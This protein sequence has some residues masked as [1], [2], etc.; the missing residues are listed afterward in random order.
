MKN[1]YFGVLEE[2]EDM[3]SILTFLASEIIE[4][5]SWGKERGIFFLIFC[6]VGVGTCNLSEGWSV[7]PSASFFHALRVGKPLTP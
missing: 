2:E 5:S 3:R 6:H 4:S 1:T 7:Q